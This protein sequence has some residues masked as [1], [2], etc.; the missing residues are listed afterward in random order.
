[1]D[2][3]RLVAL[4]L[5]QLMLLASLIPILSLLILAAFNA[6]VRRFLLWIMIP[7]AIVAILSYLAF[8]WV[9]AGEI[10]TWQDAL[11]HLYDTIT[12][13]LPYLLIL[14]II[15]IAAYLLG[16]AGAKAFR[17]QKRRAARKK[18][19]NDLLKWAKPQMRGFV[20]LEGRSFSA[21]TPYLRMIGQAGSGK[22]LLL[23]ALLIDLAQNALEDESYPLPVLIDLD[24]IPQTE[25]E[26]RQRILTGLLPAHAAN[27]SA[28]R[29]VESH[30]QRIALLID[31]SAQTFAPAFTTA[32]H[33]KKAI[34]D[35]VNIIEIFDPVRLVVALPPGIESGALERLAADVLILE[36]SD[37]IWIPDAI[38]ALGGQKAAD[39]SARLLDPGSGWGVL[40]R[41]IMIL[42]AI[43]SY[44]DGFGHP[45]TNAKELFRATLYP[46]QSMPE[47]LESALRALAYE[48]L[49][50]GITEMAREE[51]AILLRPLSVANGEGHGLLNLLHNPDRVAFS[52]PLLL[53]YFSA[54]AWE[55]GQPFQQ[56]VLANA[57]SDPIIALAIL[58][59][60]NIAGRSERLAGMLENLN[61]RSD[62]GAQYLAAQCLLALP[63]SQRPAVLVQQAAARLVGQLSNNSQSAQLA[64]ELMEPLDTPIRVQVFEQG[65][66]GIDP[67]GLGPIL[68]I[69]LN[70]SLDDARSI[71]WFASLDVARTAGEF[72]A[73]A[74]PREMLDLFIA[75]ITKGPPTRQ[76]LFIELMGFLPG[77]ACGPYLGELFKTQSDPQKRITILH[78]MFSAGVEMVMTLLAVVASPQETTEVRVAAVQLLA[79]SSS[80]EL[81]SNPVVREMVRISRMPLPDRVREHLHI[82]LDSFRDQQLI[83]QLDRWE[84]MLNPFQP[85]R[86]LTERELFFGREKVLRALRSAME[87]GTHVVLSGEQQIGKTSSLRQFELNLLDEAAGGVP[88]RSAYLDLEGLQ[89]HEFFETVIRTIIEGINDPQL[90]ADGQVVRPYNDVQ[91]EHDLDELGIYLKG[92]LGPG[93]RVALLLD[94]ADVLLDYPLSIHAGLRRI[95][96]GPAARYISL[97]LA[98]CSLLDGWHQAQ[99]P[100]YSTFQTIALGRLTKEDSIRL[101]VEPVAGTY[102]FDTEALDLIAHFTQGRPREIHALCYDLI[103]GLIE[104]GERVVNPQQVRDVIKGQDRVRVELLAETNRLLD[105]MIDW[106]GTNTQTSQPEV[107][108]YLKQTWERIGKAMLQSAKQLRKR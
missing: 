43:V 89:A 70:H 91:F 1:M 103:N 48:M 30:A 27:V 14:L 94:D 98:G 67:D 45:P 93:F 87:S 57:D 4:K 83:Q 64:W 74:Q 26:I 2:Q 68:V 16:P 75:S 66:T 62:P 104:N 20:P 11:Q 78:S 5:I 106:L 7:T 10:N 59:F 53:A 99:L 54:L 73:L 96:N 31:T 21:R 42:R 77:E 46:Q 29:Q 61:S 105:E 52:H 23:R 69:I 72:F 12:S 24:L 108:E 13:A 90:I 80:P 6:K 22:S 97:V 15:G 63:T 44:I 35:L 60:N 49:Q 40:A 50:R 34:D 101:A 47:K 102:Q 25:I 55:A 51:A 71:L 85:G 9:P 38:H 56:A 41:R 39:A 107:E 33:R 19:L 95:L 8:A 76:E 79:T 58:F 37:P 3:I 36:P 32:S 17:T 28:V 18:Y 81:H 100:F 88:V 92:S 82:L 86:P 65:L 84:S